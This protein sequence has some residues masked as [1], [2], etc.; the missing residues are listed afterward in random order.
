MKNS[1]LIK[2]NKIAGGYTKV[3][4]LA[5]IQGIYDSRTGEELIKVL[6]SINHIYLPYNGT[7]KETRESLPSDYRRKGIIITYKVD[8]ELVTEVYIGSD[9]DVND[10]ALFTAD[11]NWEIVPD[12]EFVQNNASKIPNGAIIPEHLSP[13]LWELLSKYH[14]ITNFPDEEDLTQHCKVLKFKDRST[15]AGKGYKILRKNWVGSFNI[16]EAT[17][18]SLADTIYEIRYDF[19]LNGQEITLPKNATLLFN[20]GTFNNGKVICYNTN[21]LGINKFEDAGNAEFSGTFL[22]GLILNIEDTIKWYDGNEWVSIRSGNDGEGS[23]TNLTARVVEV[24]TTENAIAEANVVDNEIQFKFGIPKGEKGDK[25]DKG[26]SGT[27]GGGSSV[28]TQTFSIFKSTGTSLNRPDTP[29]GGKWNSV[30]NVFTA[31]TGWSRNDELEGYVWMSS[32]IFRADTGQLSGTWSTPFRVTGLEGPD[33]SDG[34]NTEFIFRLSN[35]ELSAPNDTPP[36]NPLVPDFIPDLWDDHPKGVSKDMPYEYVCTRNKDS[37]TGQWGDWEGPALWSKWG[38]DGKDG[39]GVEYIYTLTSKDIRPYTPD[40]RNASEDSPTTNFQDREFIPAQTNSNGNKNEYPWTD[41]PSDVT[42]S[43]PYEWVSIRRFKWST[44]TWGPF[45]EPA[46]WAKYGKDGDVAVAAF[47]SIVFRRTNSILTEYDTPRGGNYANPI[48]EEPTDNYGKPLWTDGIPDGGEMVWMSSRIFSATGGHP[49]QEEWT[50]PRQLTD[51]ASFDV[52]FSSKENPGLPTG[53]P[54]TNIRDWSNKSDA[55]TLWMATSTM[56]NGV[57]SD[58][59]MV[60]IKGEKGDAGTSIQILGSFNSYEALVAAT[61][62]K[63]LPGNNPPNTGDCYLVNGTLYIWDGDSWFDGGG[64]KGTPGTGIKSITTRYAV[65]TSATSAPDP[66]SDVWKSTSPAT[67]SVNKYLWK[68]TVITYSNVEDEATNDTTFYEM[69]GVHGDKG[70]DGDTIEYIFCLTNTDEAPE[71]PTSSD[72]INTNNV[73]KGQWSDDAFG[74]DDKWKYEWVSSH[75]KSWNDSTQK[76]E[77]GPYSKATHWAVYSEDGRGIASITAQYAVHDKSSDE[78][79][80][81]EGLDWHTSSPAV[82]DDK[83]FLWKKTMVI[84]TDDTTSDDW[85]YEMIG[86]KGDKGIDGEGV[87]YIFKMT[88][89]NTAPETPTNINQDAL[90]DN[91]PGE[92]TDDPLTMR[93][94]NGVDYKYQWVS[95]RTKK[96]GVW[97]AYSKPSLWSELYPGLY[98]HIKY[99]NG[100]NSLGEWVFTGPNGTGED[101]G[102][103]IGVLTDYNRGDSNDPGDYTW[104]KFQGD[105]GFGREYI[106]K[107]GDDY[108]SPPNVP[109]RESGDDKPQFKPQYWSLDPIIPTPELKYCWCCHRDYRDNVWGAWSGNSTDLSKAYLFSMYAES[110][111][112]ETGDNGPILFPAGYWERNKV[113]RQVTKTVDGKEVVNATPYVYDNTE[114]SEG[115]YYLL[116]KEVQSTLSP[117]QDVYNWGKMSTFNAIYTDILLANNAKVGQAVFNG[118]YMFSQEG[119]NPQGGG[120]G[121]YEN[122]NLE[123]LP[124]TDSSIFDP[125]WCVNLVTGEQWIGAGK[126]YFSSDGSG[127]VAN[128]AIRWDS[129]GNIIKFPKSTAVIS[130]VSYRPNIL[131]QAT[132]TISGDWEK[133]EDIQIEFSDGNGNRVSKYINIK[134]VEIGKPFTATAEHPLNTVSTKFPWKEGA[135]V[136]L[137]VNNIL[138]A[139]SVVQIERSNGSSDEPSTIY[140]IAFT[141]DNLEGLCLHAFGTRTEYSSGYYDNITLDD[142]GKGGIVQ[143][144]PNEGLEVNARTHGE[145]VTVRTNEQVYV[146]LDGSNTA[147]T[148]FK[149]EEKNITV[150]VNI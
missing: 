69:I 130:A 54:N 131:I 21:L 4:P 15:S 102:K 83:P 38:A 134:N 63:T 146:F 139:E 53:H 2:E 72:P 89:D 128:K 81:L 121:K 60:R 44:Q 100:Q 11:T 30:D 141:G 85:T 74:P 112:G 6:K 35:V 36:N 70:V 45:E 133:I 149:L 129:N 98:I 80:N 24:K 82:T 103:Y 71:V 144:N 27:G 40:G 124:Y 22:K 115:Y 136:R 12:L 68:E 79:Y 32:G 87:E 118:D 7:S 91:T 10:D 84:F 97:S 135:V 123:G 18:V 116:T 37:I 48:P 147:I 94:I 16:L 95:Q 127:Y 93:K 47:K 119:I 110:V 76:M 62:N 142:D 49:Q 64:I 31:P 50:T 25:G 19:D 92:W 78:K 143:W 52:E 29:T 117:S 57:W 140:T 66:D 90:E 59:T 41:N 145:I 106:F 96:D 88:V 150:N 8:D 17:E 148:S 113:Y 75:V 5:Y 58:W 126:I 86:K 1:Q 125:N 3:Y 20:G 9:K 109:P 114:G 23:I 77:W 73:Q 101:V 104:R 107:L 56:N 108:N 42:F 43:T 67:D 61:N 105:D 55:T 33:G 111:K 120:K 51:T 28:T 99:S 13:A 122:F 46:L 34:V 39:D 14:T 138:Y 26:D 132:G 137:Y 65:H